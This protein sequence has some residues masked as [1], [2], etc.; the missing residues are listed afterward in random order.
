MGTLGMKILVIDVGGS[1]VKFKLWGTRRKAGFESGKQMTPQ[2]MAKLV[3][4]MTKDWSYD[5]ISIGFPGPV[6][7][8]RP[9]VDPQNLGKGW[10][11]FNFEKYFRKPVKVINDAAMQA[12]GS[13]RGGR[14]L[15]VGLGTGLGSALILD[16]VIVPLELGEL[17]YSKNQTVAD[18]LGRNAL[19]KNGLKRWSKAVHRII[20]RF[21]AAFLT[22][23]LV[24]G[25]G[26]AKYLKRLPRSARR[27][28][29]SKAFAGGA[30]MWHTGEIYA[31]PRKHTWVIT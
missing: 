26:N 9:A 17:V 6:I 23:S 16:E 10:T 27:G 25:G 2:R 18:V 12:L 19:E 13:Y 8:G 14:M 1:K 21:A 20:R 3:S 31:R 29:N 5:A 4:G 15:F 28:S 24:I 22:E 30:R 11:R 7:H